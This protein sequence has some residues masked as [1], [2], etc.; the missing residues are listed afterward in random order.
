VELLVLLSPAPRARSPS[1]AALERLAGWALGLTAL[2]WALRDALEG[3]VA[4]PVGAT[5]ALLNLAAGVCFA[6]RRPAKARS[7]WP[8]QLGVLGSVASSGVVLALAP[9]AEV[10]PSLLAWTFALGGAAALTSLVFLGPRFGVLPAW[11]G[12]ARRGPYRLVR[13]PLYAS[14]LVMV[15]AAAAAGWSVP[16]LG[17]GAGAIALLALR[18]GLEERLLARRRS[19]RRYA[20]RVRWRLVPGLW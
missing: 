5:L 10:W 12:L 4:H 13:H 17:A 3:R 14:E 2:G 20:R 8:H 15:L 18:I 7:P 9:P 19:Y 6:L 11:R 1:D 16:A